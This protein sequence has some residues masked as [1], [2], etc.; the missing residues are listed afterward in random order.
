MGEQAP[1]D[2]ITREGFIGLAAE[3]LALR[4]SEARHE[5]KFVKV[6]MCAQQLEGVFPRKR[7]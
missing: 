3:V 1:A 5:R 7:V 4:Q 2:E 6:L